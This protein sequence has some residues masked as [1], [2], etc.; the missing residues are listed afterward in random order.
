MKKTGR[1]NVIYRLLLLC[2]SGAGLLILQ[3][4]VSQQFYNP[5]TAIHI[6]PATPYE[7]VEFFSRD[8][9][10]LKGWYIPAVTETP[11]GTIVHF[12]GNTGSMSDNLAFVDWVP[13]AGYNLFMFDYRGFGQSEGKITRRGVFDDSR[14]A[15]NYVGTRP[16]VDRNRIVVFGQSLGGANALA[17]L[18]RFEYPEVQAIVIDSAFYSYR[19]VAED[20]VGKNSKIAWAKKPLSWLLVPNQ[21]SPGP[22]VHRIAPT[23]LLFFHG[24]DDRVIHQ[25]HGER[26]FARAREPK[27]WVSVEGGRHHHSFTRF[28]DENVARVQAF[29]DEVWRTE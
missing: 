1:R 2:I 23:P 7:P 5:R 13:D 10:R 22:V 8:K 27:Q 18:G 25:S 12:H 26:L 28:R 16:D 4:C 11:K 21:L 20:Q 24:T 19:S 3:G 15:L 14:A 6:V 29:L 17:V 9:T